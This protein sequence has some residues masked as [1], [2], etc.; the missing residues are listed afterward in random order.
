MK[1][2]FSLLMV[3]TLV[4]QLFAGLTVFAADENI[5]FHF[6]TNYIELTVGETWDAA[7]HLVNTTGNSTFYT[8]RTPHGV[9]ASS[10]Q[11]NPITDK[12]TMIQADAIGYTTMTASSAVGSKVANILVCVKAVDEDTALKLNKPYILGQQGDTFQLSVLNNTANTAVTWSSGSSA[13]VSVDQTGKV[14]ILTNVRKNVIVTATV[15]ETTLTCSITITHTSNTAISNITHYVTNKND[16]EQLFH[17]GYVSA[18]GNYIRLFDVYDAS[19]GW[20]D[21]NYSYGETGTQ[22]GIRGAGTN[23]AILAYRAPYTGTLGIY[24]N[25][26]LALNSTFGAF[27]ILKSGLTNY[28]YTTNCT[29]IYPTD[30]DYI[31]LA[32]LE[33]IQVNEVDYCYALP[34]LTSSTPDNVDKF[35]DGI[36]VSVNKGEYIYI[37]VQGNSSTTGL[38]TKNRGFEF[39]YDDFNDVK[40]RYI[41][42]PENLN[43][44]VLTNTSGSAAVT[45]TIG[46]GT[47]KYYTSNASVATV[48]ETT[49]AVSVVKA[50]SCEI[51][52][53]ADDKVADKCKVTVTDKF[54]VSGLSDGTVTVTALP[55]AAEKA[56]VIAGVKDSTGMLVNAYLGEAKAISTTENTVFTVNGITKGEDEELFV[57]IW[58]SVADGMPVHGVTEVK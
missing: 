36:K 34:G 47:V 10:W 18:T 17:S 25:S 44:D 23:W 28:E 13:D 50:G 2:V 53:V 8:S 21:Q 32:D 6:D 57:Y 46:A 27:K 39:K 37:M 42:M 56:V 33:K 19:R 7:E 14:K 48:D 29:K 20:H 51:Y 43:L 35:A 26:G 1:K 55:G 41:E 40:E 16:R 38:Y 54:T 24:L 45:A 12:R 22:R 9:Q 52:A 3:L 31:T 15:G 30:K 11:N 4:V 49:G 58:D 5:L